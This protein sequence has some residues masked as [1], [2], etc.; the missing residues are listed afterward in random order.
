MHTSCIHCRVS[1]TYSKLIVHRKRGIGELALVDEWDSFKCE[2]TKVAR[3]YLHDKGGKVEFV[4]RTLEKSLVRID[5]A[6]KKKK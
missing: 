4:E 1:I 3:P 5:A 6:G 2:L